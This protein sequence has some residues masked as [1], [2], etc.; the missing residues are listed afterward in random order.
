MTQN[1]FK[2]KHFQ[3]DEIMQERGIN[4]T[5]TTTKGV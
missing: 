4:V 1:L 5:H 2:W 3:T